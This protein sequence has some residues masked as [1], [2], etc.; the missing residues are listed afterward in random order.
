M[1]KKFKKGIERKID[2]FNLII[3]NASGKVFGGS[4]GCINSQWIEGV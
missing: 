4:P 3:N 1:I 2:K